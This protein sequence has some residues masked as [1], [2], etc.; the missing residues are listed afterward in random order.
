MAGRKLSRRDALET[1]SGILYYSA[2]LI[3]GGREDDWHY[4]AVSDPPNVLSNFLTIAIEAE[5]AD[6]RSKDFK[7]TLDL[8]GFEKYEFSTTVN[9]VDLSNSDPEAIDAYR[10]ETTS[11]LKAVLGADDVV[12][13]DT[14]VRNKDTEAPVKPS[15]SPFVGPYMRVHVD[16]NPRSALARLKH[17]V[18]FR[19]GLRRFQILNVWRPLIIP[20][21]NYPLALCD[22]QSLNPHKDL[23]ATRRLLPEW[24]H[25]LWVQDR[26]GYSLKHSAEHRWYYWKFLTPSEAIVFKCHDSA[27]TSLA[28]GQEGRDA[29][30]QDMPNSIEFS[31]LDVSG[32]CPHTAFFDRRS[33]D[34]GHLRSSVD[35]R[36]LALYY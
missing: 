24:M 27:S 1:A 22:Y 23:I 33:P 18:G 16:Q 5:I 9:Q 20:V 31:L 25:E 4:D 3:P 21:K 32:L 28:L 36:V 6:L 8:W 17:H 2:P 10:D 34:Q 26:E 13:F 15:A 11:Y 7:P 14:V 35:V 30:S 12:L 29:R 19:A